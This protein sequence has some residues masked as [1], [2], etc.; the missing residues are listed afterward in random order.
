MARFDVLVEVLLMTILLGCVYNE[1]GY[2]YFEGLHYLRLRTV[3]DSQE[4]ALRASK[5]R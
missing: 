4:K 1:Q 2:R 3:L 5:Q